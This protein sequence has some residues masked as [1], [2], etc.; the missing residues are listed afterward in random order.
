MTTVS[1]GGQTGGDGG[2]AGAMVTTSGDGQGLALR[3]TAHEATLETA[4]KGRATGV[5][6]KGE[7]VVG[8]LFVSPALAILLLFLVVP[9]LL[10]VYIS[11]T[12][13]SGLTPPLSSSVHLV[14]LKNYRTLLTTAGLY[15]TNFGTAVRDNFYFVI[16]TVPLQTALALFMAAL[17]NGKYLRARSFFRTSFY[18]PSVTS[19][20]AITMVFIFLFQGSGVI[21]TVLG[22]F[23]AKG[24]DWIVDQRGLFWLVLQL[25][26]V[27]NPPGW[28][29]NHG[30][31]G[32]N[33][34]NWLAGPSL[35]MCVIICLLVWTTSGTFMLY[36]LAGLSQIGEDVDEASEID[37]ANRWQRFRHVTL[38]LLRPVLV[39]VLTLGFISTW[40]V[41]DQIYMVGPSN[42]T[43]VTP[44]YYSYQVS[45][46]DSAFGM[47]AAVAFLLFCLIV[48]LTVLQRKFV[49]ED[50][51][52]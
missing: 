34:W 14:G 22:W 48:F 38:P 21:N 42:P 15:Q 2:A 27:N 9:I 16:F 46:Q 51:T 47:G 50:L 29:A 43:T 13:W 41:F 37:G 26:G 28:A 23:G 19:S 1:E 20:I 33:W 5:L 24:P 35:G 17:V 36:F 3:T 39:L 6:R 49:K 25:F 4:P 52:Q 18:F 8:W 40:Q 12:N 11:F 30:F 32:I 7:G 10:A 45:F 31:L 44:A